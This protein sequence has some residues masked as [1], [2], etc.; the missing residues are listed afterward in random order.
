MKYILIVL[1]LL[2][3]FSG[4][5]QSEFTYGFLP[6]VA[7]S[8]R[9]DEKWR[10]STQLESMQ[11]SFVNQGQARIEG[12]EYIRTDFTTL[13][14]YQIAPNWGVGVGALSRFENNAFIFRSIQQLTFNKRG[15][16]VRY[17]HRLRTDQT[18]EPQEDL[19]LRLR[20]RF[21][22]E[23]PLQGETLNDQEFYT[24]WSVEQIG[25]HQSRKLDWEQ[26]L[27]GVLGYYFNDQHKIEIGLDYR[28]DKFLDAPGRHRVWTMLNY[29]L[30][31]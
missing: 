16:S 6:E 26:R 11:Q 23:V 18:F 10:I 13:L 7:V 20:Y 12:Y 2:I 22:V 25:I 24:L 8:Y 9:W 27:S 29:Y 30:N 14:T 4:Q 21:S 1:F 3:N 5:A 15:P 19:R 17:G 28:L 31:L